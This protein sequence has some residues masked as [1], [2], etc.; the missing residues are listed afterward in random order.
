[1][2]GTIEQRVNEKTNEIRNALRALRKRL[3]AAYIW[4]NRASEEPHLS[5]TTDSSS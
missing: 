5:Y 2:K 4:V 3:E 1:M